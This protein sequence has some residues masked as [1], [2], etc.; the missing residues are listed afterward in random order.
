MV[1]DPVLAQIVTVSLATLFAAAGV[2]KLVYRRRFAGVL[3]AY[4]LLPSWL[5]PFLTIIVP[6]LELG[7]AGGLLI[8]HHKQLVIAT[9]VVLLATYA[10]AMA[11]NIGRGRRDIDC[12][13]HLSGEPQLINRALVARN[14]LLALATCLLLLPTAERTLVWFDFGVI[15]FGVVMSALLYGAGNHLAATHERKLAP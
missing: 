10:L 7:V 6:V 5:I 13:C 9:A 1:V 14:L 4:A 11:I 15:I 3:E 12:G 2:Q 8:T